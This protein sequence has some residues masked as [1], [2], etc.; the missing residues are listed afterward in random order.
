MNLAY[1]S[2]EFGPVTG[3][4]IGTY[5]ANVCRAFAA[6]G[7]RVYLVTDCFARADRSLLPT[8]VT[9]VET[10][11]S[12]AHQ[13]GYFFNENQEYAYR[14]LHTLRQLANQQL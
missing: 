2:R 5:I 7:H 3:G 1:V 10:L 6:A 13:K 8:G 14:V 9:L 4:G 11:P 12:L